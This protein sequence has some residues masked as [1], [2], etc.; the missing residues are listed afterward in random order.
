MKS[1]HLFLLVALLILIDQAIKVYVKTHFHLG[2]EYI[3]IKDWFRINF[4]ENGGMIFGWDP[5]GKGFKILNTLARLTFCVGGIFVFRYF[6]R[7][8]FSK[9]FFVCLAFIYAGGVGNLIDNLFY[10]VLFG[11]G[12]LLEGKVVD[13]FYF[14]LI[15]TTLPSWMPFV[16][17]N[18][19]R[20]FEYVF[21]FADV[22]IDI[23]AFTLI[24][25]NKKFIKK[26]EH[27]DPLSESA[28]A[29]SQ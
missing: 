28:N 8:G 19:F 1:R 12:H 24:L 5:G 27:A 9:G 20:F 3:V 25:F 11:G 21:N 29:V 2:E 6:L 18:R 23:G 4:V 17:G 13:M 7:K 14:P 15:D 16:G 26:K 10:G 22:C